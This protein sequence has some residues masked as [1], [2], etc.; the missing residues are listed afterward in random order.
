MGPEVKA[1]AV[2]YQWR[3]ETRELGRRSET[4]EI[5]VQKSQ[6]LQVLVKE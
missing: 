5:E 2:F 4:Q 6:L 1:I 3:K